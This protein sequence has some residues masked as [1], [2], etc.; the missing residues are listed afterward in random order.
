[1]RFALAGL[2]LLVLLAS[3][4]ITPLAAQ[5]PD[6]MPYAALASTKFMALPVLPACM[7]ISAQRG[8]PMKDAAVLLLKVKSGCIVP[9]HWHTANEN[10]MMVSGSAKAEMSDGANTL[11]AGDYLYLAGKQIHQF[12]CISSCVVFDVIDGAFDIHYV[13]KDG[14]EIPVEQALKP[15]AKPATAKKP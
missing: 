4:L 12:T 13:D 10:L 15:T 14:N 2:S 1:M 7:T 11:V 8:D 6:Q 3:A 9:W 5:S